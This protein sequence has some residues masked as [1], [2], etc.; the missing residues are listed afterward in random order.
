MASTQ[1][2][3][4]PL[5]VLNFVPE[6]HEK[7]LKQAFYN[8]AAILFVAF[9]FTAAV[10]VYFVFEPFLEPL[11]WAVLFGSVLHP[12]KQ[13]L[14]LLFRGWLKG[15]HDDGTPLAF[16]LIAS[17]FK[18]IDSI[19]EGI[20]YFVLNYIQVF[21]GLAVGLPMLYFIYGLLPETF[22]FDL[23]IG[24]VVFF[25]SASNVLEF[26]S[27]AGLLVWT[28][29]IGYILLVVIWWTPHSQRILPLMS[30]C[31]W[32]TVIF[33][34]ATIAG[35]LRVP[36]L[37]IL[38]V[39]LVVGFFTEVKENWKQNDSRVEKDIQPS[40]VGSLKSTTEWLT[41]G[42]A[43]TEE[44]TQVMSNELE[45]ASQQ[46]VQVE[47]STPERVSQRL[48][49]P[50]SLPLTP[51]K[52]ETKSQAKLSNLYLYGLVWAC[53][54]TEIWLN[55][56]LLN[57]LPLPVIYIVIK[58]LGCHFGLFSFIKEKLS[59]AWAVGMD[60]CQSRKE[61]L[62][63]APVRGLG[64]MLARG[65]RKVIA[66][67]EGS[68]DTFTSIGVILIVLILTVVGT[69][70]LSVQIYGE[71]MHLVE[72]TSNLINRVVVHNPELQQLLPEKLQDV[73]G[74]LDSMVGNAYVYGREW[75]S[76]TVRDFIDEKDENRAA[77]VEEQ[78]LEVWDRIYHLWI[79][80]NATN[81][82]SAFSSHPG[83]SW[84]DLVDG[85]KTLN[86]TLLVSYVQENIGTLIAVL[87]SVWTVVIGNLSL[88]FS[89]LTAI[90]SLLF[91]GGT[92]VLNFLLD[93]VVFSTALFYLLCASGT[94]Y[95]PVEM[96]SMMLPSGGAGNKVGEVVEQSINGVFAASF[97]MAAF[98]G[99]YTWLI[100]T[101]FD[102][103]IIYI[104]SVL[105]AIFGAVPFLGGYWACLPAVLELW[106]VNGQVFRAGL[107][108]IGQ[109][110]PTS[111]VD[112]AVY[113]EI[114]GGGHP[115]LTG[116]AIAGGVFCLGFRGALFGPML[117]CLL[118]VAINMY[119]SMMQDTSST[120]VGQGGARS[121]LK[122]MNTVE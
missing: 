94:L 86:L 49:K 8:T 102:V 40:S 65:D 84:S 33:H 115:Y 34:F 119:S 109:L 87:E 55:L 88:A 78:I 104:P 71:S 13:K 116:L 54:L 70:F 91:G 1:Y 56:W 19:S 81:V 83:M 46:K 82:T 37:F 28:L 43:Y 74:T 80:R 62:V 44:V 97:K 117:L 10:A 58:K 7:A 110:A 14:T 32:M 101:I 39:L 15:L 75:I 3:K 112:S 98:Y 53:I 22:S 64:K 16:G 77:V 17:P 23:W 51:R 61:A 30:V 69:I 121:L 66:V 20:G 18:V 11:L 25:Q 63:P 68:I 107:M 90:L 38:L 95:K 67:L 52:N 59:A 118:M 113:S 60:W 103:N 9:A 99:L 4:S 76:T 92:A 47:P 105:A 45:N 85:M 26:F 35:F 72:V 21:I 100:H 27:N 50:S 96:V 42:S 114:K 48:T 122:R 12:F 108:F 120:R 31:V 57:L 5:D 93:F 79:T 36:I 29:V 89:S 2:I 106:L 6:G 24:I 111:F 41:E 73:Q